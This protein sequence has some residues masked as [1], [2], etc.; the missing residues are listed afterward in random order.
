MRS[1]AA[2][3]VYLAASTSALEVMPGS[4]PVV[5]RPCA[6]R[7]N[8]TLLPVLLMIPFGVKVSELPWRSVIDRSSPVAPIMYAVPYGSVYVYSSGA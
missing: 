2:S 8:V 6:S 7:T 5:I 3:Y 1:P 4:R